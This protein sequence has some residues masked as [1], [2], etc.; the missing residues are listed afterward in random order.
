MFNLLSFLDSIIFCILLIGVLYLFVFAYFAMKKPNIQYRK[1]NKLSKI[2]VFFPAYKE[3]SVIID[4]ISSFLKQSYPKNLYQIIL[5]ADGFKESTLDILKELPIQVLAVNFTSSTKAKAL[6][7]AV[8]QIKDTNFEIAVILDADNKTDANFL[9]DINDAFC[10]GI[11]AIQAHRVAANLNSDTAV[12]D[13]VSEEINNSIF[14]RGHVRAGFSSALIGS[15]MAFSYDWFKDN[16]KLTIS[17]GEDKE[18]EKLLLKQGIYIAYLPNT[19]VYDQKV[20]NSKNFYKQRRRWMAAQLDIMSHST[21]D[22]VNSLLKGNWD[23]AN[24]IFQWMMLPRVILLAL[25]ILMTALISFIEFRWAIKWWG[26]LFLFLITMAM[27]LPDNLV[28]KKFK[29][30]MRHIPILAIYMILNLFRLKG[31]NKKF[32][33]TEH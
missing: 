25:I 33:H 16:I 10:D 28:D 24:K 19:F 29:R 2:A 21:G 22:F 13:A 3:D 27:A 6:N 1:S 9:A 12:L 30:A 17:A 11:K 14:R 8:E 20:A 5:I 18:L 7:Y 23:Y 31:V 26:L 15:G 32:I 4:S